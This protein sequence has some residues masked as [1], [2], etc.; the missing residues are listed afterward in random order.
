[1]IAERIDP[2]VLWQL[3]M[4]RADRYS[5]VAKRMSATWLATFHHEVF[6][7]TVND[8]IGRAHV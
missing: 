2:K 1:V 7:V 3:D 6:D 5:A 4:R 8:Q